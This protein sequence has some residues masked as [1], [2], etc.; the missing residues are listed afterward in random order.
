MQFCKYDA[1]HPCKTVIG[2]TH[3]IIMYTKM[4]DKIKWQ[5]YAFEWLLD[6]FSTFHDLPS[7][8]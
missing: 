8:A 7:V 1:V 3:I 6:N 5:N 4:R 2:N